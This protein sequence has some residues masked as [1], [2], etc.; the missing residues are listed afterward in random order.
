MTVEQFISNKQILFVRLKYMLNQEL[1]SQ[2]K[3]LEF[4]CSPT[5]GLNHID[6]PFAKQRGIEIICLKDE[7]KFLKDIRATSEHTLGLIL[8]LLRNYQRAFSNHLSLESRDDLKGFEV[9]DNRIGIIGYGRI[10]QLLSSY[11]KPLGAQC[12]FYDVQ[13]KE[14]KHGAIRLSSPEQLIDQCNVI[15]LCASYEVDKEILISKE[16][17]DAMEGKYFINT[18]RGELVEEDYLIQKIKRGHFAGI[19][20]DVIQNETNLENADKFKGIDE[21]QNFI[22]TPH[23]GG[24]SFTSMERTEVFIT[25]RFLRMIQTLNQ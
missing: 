21:K 23:I 19:A 1:L 5:T 13:E 4:I 10:G 15:V 16:L 2:A 18:S 17:I 24:A 8:S 7:V 11:L 20:L 9:Y 3:R 22:Y 12:Y 14:E 6:L 25:E